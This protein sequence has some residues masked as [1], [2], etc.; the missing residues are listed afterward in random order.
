[1]KSL[2]ICCS[3]GCGIL[4]DSLKNYKINEVLFVMCDIIYNFAATDRTAK[5]PD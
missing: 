1:M 3:L 2:I 4:P 5:A